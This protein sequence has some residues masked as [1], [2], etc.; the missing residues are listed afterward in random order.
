MS[1][2][3]YVHT[4]TFTSVSNMSFPIFSVGALST[5]KRFHG[6]QMFVSTKIPSLAAS[7]HRLF[8]SAHYNKVKSFICFQPHRYEVCRSFESKTHFKS[9][10]NHHTLERLYILFYL[11]LKFLT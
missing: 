10:I 5:R 4:V 2:L 7:Y 9:F 6:M 1:A 11:L 8:S 3:D